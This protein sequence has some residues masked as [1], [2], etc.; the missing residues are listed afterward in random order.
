[1]SPV[2][3]LTMVYLKEKNISKTEQRKVR[4]HINMKDNSL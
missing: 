2:I 1:M 3:V 4:C